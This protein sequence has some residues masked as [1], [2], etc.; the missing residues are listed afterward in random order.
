M[1][2]YNDLDMPVWK[3]YDDIYDVD[4]MIEEDFREHLERL[5]EICCK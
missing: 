5:S 3:E 1:E 4:N 2:K